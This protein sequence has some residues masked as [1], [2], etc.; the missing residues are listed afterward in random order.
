MIAALEGGITYTDWPV[1][2]NALLE[3]FGPTHDQ[4][5]AR[6]GVFS[7]CQRGS[8]ETYITE[9]TRLNL[10]VPELDELYRSFLFANRL[11]REF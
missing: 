10:Q 6:L 1:L 11:S 2:R 9:F 7:A 3:A 8:L 5:R 4:E